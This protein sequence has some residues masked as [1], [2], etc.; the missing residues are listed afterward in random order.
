MHNYRVC[1]HEEP[2]CF[3]YGLLTAK[4]V[5][6]VTGSVKTGPIAH[7]RKF[8]FLSLTQ[9]TIKFHYQNEVVLSGLL[10]LAAFL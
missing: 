6:F 3:S 2:F 4:H 7:D 8:N 9:Y 5:L 1:Q 10:L